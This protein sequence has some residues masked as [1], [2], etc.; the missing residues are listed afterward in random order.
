MLFIK[1]LSQ[2]ISSYFQSTSGNLQYDIALK[3]ACVLQGT[4]I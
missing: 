4:E 2:I 3:Y 1:E